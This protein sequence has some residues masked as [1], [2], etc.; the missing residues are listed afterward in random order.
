MDRR[1]FVVFAAFALMF[2]SVAFTCGAQSV[3]AGAVDLGVVVTR[4]DGTSYKLYWAASNLSE[5]GLCPNPEDYGDYYAWG[6]TKA[7]KDYSWN[8]YKWCN[9]SDD[10]LTRYNTDSSKGAVDN[11]TVL[12]ASDDVAHVKLGGKWRMPTDVEWAGLKKQCT[13]T[14]TSRNGVDGYEVIGPNGKSLFLPAAGGWYNSNLLSVGSSG[15]YWSSS[16]Y[17]DCT[18]DAMYV[19]F[20][21]ALVGR[22]FYYR[23]FG[24]SVRPVSE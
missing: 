6:E 12:Q 18:F 9:G 2:A 1:L 15:N 4:V 20:Y 19:E 13:W 22:I 21:S 3:P 16:L 8:S 24:F 7:K 11:K 17:S 23:C 5:D 14:W 10:S